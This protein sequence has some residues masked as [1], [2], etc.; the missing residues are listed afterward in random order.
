MPFALEQDAVRNEL[1]NSQNAMPVYAAIVASTVHSDSLKSDFPQYPL[2]KML[3]AFRREGA[4][5]FYH[6]LPKSIVAVS[7]F[8][9]WSTLFFVGGLCATFPEGLRH[10]L[11]QPKGRGVIE[12]GSTATLG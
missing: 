9:W 8:I 12:L 5:R 10:A 11:K 2:T 1:V 7:L 6:L 3:E 4:Q